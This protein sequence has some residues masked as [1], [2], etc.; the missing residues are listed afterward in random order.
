MPYDNVME[1]TAQPIQSEP[2]RATM[3][4]CTTTGVADLPLGGVSSAS[5]LGLAS[6][7]VDLGISPSSML[8]LS[9]F[10]MEDCKIVNNKMRNK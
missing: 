2:Q 8:S 7:I 4:L 3:V 10:F 1:L 5:P 9:I 6:K